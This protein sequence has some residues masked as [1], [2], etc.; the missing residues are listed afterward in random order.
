[1]KLTFVVANRKSGGVQRVV[2]NLARVADATG[3]QVTVL[4]LTNLS[5]GHLDFGHA[6]VKVI[7]K[8]K[9]RT[10]FVSLY[11]YLKSASRNDVFIVGQ[12]HVNLAVLFLGKIARTEARM[13]I[14]EH[15]PIDIALTKM[16]AIIQKM[17]WRFYL[18]S[19]GIISVS[20]DIEQEIKSKISNV[21]L[22]VTTIY[23][24]VEPPIIKKLNKSSTSFPSI[25]RPLRVSCIGRLHPQK[26]FSLAIN[27]VAEYQRNGGNIF[28]QIVGQGEEFTDLEKLANAVL[29]KGTFKFAGFQDKIYDVLKDTDCL[30]MTSRW[31]G[32]GIVAVEALY[33]GVQVVSTKCS[34]PEE[35]LANGLYGKLVGHSPQDIAR[36]LKDI[37]ENPFDPISLQERANEL[38]NPEKVFAQYLQF[39]EY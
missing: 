33:M 21:N 15:N 10:A 25:Q 6:K 37:S 28:L 27:A 31:E 2:S 13:F 11:R 19:A 30:L 38:S 1:M 36:G 32:F 39:I 35:I 20:K 18:F 9:V 17:K 24:P 5:D 7:G 3:Y 12:P 29:I 8:A 26:N 4:V 23:N 16:E 22:P 34:G 14:T